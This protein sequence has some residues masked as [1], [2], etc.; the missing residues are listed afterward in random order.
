MSVPLN[1]N[2]FVSYSRRDDEGCWVSLIVEELSNELTRTEGTQI[3]LFFDKRD[4]P[5]ESDWR[6]E[7]AWAVRQA[8]V[9][10][11]FSSPHYFDSQMCL[12]EFQEY[13]DKSS[14]STAGAPSSLVPVFVGPVDPEQLPSKK[15]RRWYK[16][17]HRQECKL[18]ITSHFVQVPV[19]ALPREVAAQVRALANALHERRQQ[20]L[21]SQ[22]VPTNLGRG[23]AHFVGRVDELDDLQQALWSPG[24]IGVV[25]SVHGLGGLGKTELV[26]QHAHRHKDHYTGGI[27]QLNAEKAG[28][29]LPLI[30][31]LAAEL[32]EL[33]LPEEARGNPEAV[34]RLVLNHLIARTA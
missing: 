5:I 4:I 9:L 29:L 16:Q 3:R 2:V 34:G 23:T 31:Q 7:L 32:P 18:D 25:T 26:R 27:W 11:A 24:S 28:E 21:R 33:H 15:H 22:G 17:V 14:P 30:A 13:K 12:W 19:H 1:Y 6:S 8:E 20:R 10:L